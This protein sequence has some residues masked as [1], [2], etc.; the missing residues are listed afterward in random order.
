MVIEKTYV[1]SFPL[2]YC[3]DST[4]AKI[5]KRQWRLRHDL[6][7]FDWRGAIFIDVAAGGMGVL[8]IEHDSICWCLLII[9]PHQFALQINDLSRAFTVSR[10]TPERAKRE[11]E[12]DC[13]HV[14]L[15][16]SLSLSPLSSSHSSLPLYLFSLSLSSSLPLSISLPIF[17]SPLPLSIIGS[18]D[19]FIKIKITL[20]E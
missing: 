7:D 17:L 14:S 3:H 13:C 9:K 8:A 19:L 5:M 18:R 16:L 10:Y 2:W 4:N 6:A 20:Y 1:E 12:R 15:S 11:R